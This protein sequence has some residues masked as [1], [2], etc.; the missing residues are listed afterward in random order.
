MIERHPIAFYAH[1]CYVT[2]MSKKGKLC[3][4]LKFCNN[5]NL[6][7]NH[8]NNNSYFI[9]IAGM[10]KALYCFTESKTKYNSMN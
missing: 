6:Y 2:S 3:K 10:Y 4:P 5:N 7:H 9:Y 8:N 1:G